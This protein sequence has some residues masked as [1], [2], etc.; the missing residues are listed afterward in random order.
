MKALI[1]ISIVLAGL[2]LLLPAGAMAQDAPKA[3]VFGGYSY[4]NADRG[5]SLNGWN[6]SVTV[7]LNSWF[8]VAGDFSGHYGS[9]SFRTFVPGVGPLTASADG[10]LHLFTFGPVISYHKKNRVTPF[11]HALFGVAHSNFGGD[12]VV[13]V[14]GTGPVSFNLSEKDNAFA[15]ALGGGVD[16]KLNRVLAWRLVQAD[17]VLT[18]FG[19][20]NQNNARISTGLVFRF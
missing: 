16:V 11:A 1:K 20:E 6:A 12:T 14:P 19:S 10:N 13:F 9:D 5:S 7:N 18:H 4:F 3:E 15:M 2:F 8:G 17:Y